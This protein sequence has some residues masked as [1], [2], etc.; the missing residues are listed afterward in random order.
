MKLVRRKTSNYTNSHNN[1]STIR[2]SVNAP[3]IIPKG[4]PNW[5]EQRPPHRRPEYGVHISNGG[6]VSKAIANS[7]NSREKKR[8]NDNN[9][10]NPRHYK[11]QKTDNIPYYHKSRKFN[12]R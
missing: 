11:I 2:R 4:I 12:K 10:D 7:I 6:I 1:N 8:K 3:K 9:N 5:R